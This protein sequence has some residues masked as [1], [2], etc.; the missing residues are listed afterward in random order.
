M[1]LTTK[2][3]DELSLLDSLIPYFKV[4]VNPNGQLAGIGSIKFGEGDAF[5]KTLFNESLSYSPKKLRNHIRQ[6]IY[7]NVLISISEK[8]SSENSFRSNSSNISIGGVF[9]IAPN[10]W[11]ITNKIWVKF[12]DFKEIE[13]IECYSQWHLSWGLGYKALPGYGLEYVNLSQVQTE[14]INKIIFQSGSSLRK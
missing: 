9:I 8:F 6:D 4:R 11:N 5:F 12:E 7:L 10:E 1:K 3:R 2:E 14:L 13:P